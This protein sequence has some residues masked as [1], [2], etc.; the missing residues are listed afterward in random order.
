MILFAQHQ[1]Q[2]IETAAQS[3]W[4][5]ADLAIRSGQVPGGW[6]GLAVLALIG[7]A[8]VAAWR[9]GWIAKIWQPAPSP[10]SASAPEPA[11]HTAGDSAPTSA[12]VLP[13]D[14][15]TLNSMIRARRE[16]LTVD[17]ALAAAT[18]I[19]NDD[20]AEAAADFQFRVETKLAAKRAG[21]SSV[22]FQE[23][24]K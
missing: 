15:A 8:I 2:P 1:Q 10:P 16:R 3:A 4:M 24:A 23:V 20:V 11:A 6:L 18:E 22:Q 21:Q 13:A 19:V 7:A 5:A 14:Y 9:H 12:P 17:R